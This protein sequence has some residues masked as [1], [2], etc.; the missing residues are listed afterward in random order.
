MCSG[1]GRDSF[2]FDASSVLDRFYCIPVSM[3]RRGSRYE[4]YNFLGCNAVSTGK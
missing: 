1:I 3:D 2:P 4:D